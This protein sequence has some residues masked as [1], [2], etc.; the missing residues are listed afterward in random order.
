[1]AT[2]PLP[3]TTT[4]LPEMLLLAAASICSVKKTVPKPVASLRTCEPP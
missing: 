2:L 3:E 4:R 1:M